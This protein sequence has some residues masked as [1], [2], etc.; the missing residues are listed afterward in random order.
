MT[1]SLPVSVKFVGICI[2][3]MCETMRKVFS[4]VD[5]IFML[6]E[7]LSTQYCVVT[8]LFPSSQNFPFILSHNHIPI[9]KI[10][11][12]AFPPFTTS[13]RVM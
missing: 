4:F 2:N 9:G 3:S 7:M 12:T 13:P 1:D 5:R 6:N 10:S 8:Y 11:T